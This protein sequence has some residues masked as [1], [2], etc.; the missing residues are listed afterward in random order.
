[1][2]DIIDLHVHSHCSDGTF[3]PTELVHL[4]AK[5][6]L[7]AFALTDHDTTEGIDEAV[8]AGHL[9]NIEV[10]PGIE[11]STN[12]HGKDIHIVGLGIEKDNAYFQESLLRFQNSRDIRN[13]KMITKLQESGIH[14]TNESMYERF[15]NAIWTRA[16]FARFLQENGYVQKMWDAFPKYIGDDAPCFVP[17]EKVT[18][19]QGIQLIHEGGGKAILAHPLLYGYTVDELDCLVKELAFAG[20]DGMEV[21]YSMNGYGDEHRMKLLAKKYQLKPSGG[22]DF[23]GSN[24]PSIQLG[25]G[26][27][28]LCISYD[29]WK[30]IRS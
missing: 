11:L 13:L 21:M 27:G 3:S 30:S 15:G 24:K 29:V 19:F 14:I 8:L 25:T 12:Y 26:K 17:R 23:H 7:K 22:S 4:A 1:M 5:K 20:L 16:H 2:K 10:I 6:D 18:P 28:N 9:L